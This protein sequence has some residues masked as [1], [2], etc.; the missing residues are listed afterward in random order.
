[1]KWILTLLVSCSLLSLFLAL[2]WG[3]KPRSISLIDLSR[4]QEETAIGGYVYRAMSRTVARTQAFVYAH[5][6]THAANEIAL[7][8]LTSAAAQGQHWERV[9]ARQTSGEDLAQRIG[10]AVHLLI[11]A[12]PDFA[13]G[14]GREDGVLPLER[15][16]GFTTVVLGLTEL[17]RS[18][19]C[20]DIAPLF[21]LTDP[22][23][24]ECAGH[25]LTLKVARKRRAQDPHVFAL[26][27]FGQNTYVL[28]VR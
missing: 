8:F 26:E 7:G 17:R 14:P 20:Q 15:V 27:Q 10:P 21:D 19:P 12:P 23:F 9:D 16:F 18:E 2:K 28:F 13:F 4:Y 3:V 22:R 5:E 11:D 24:L 25:Y 6:E 1:M